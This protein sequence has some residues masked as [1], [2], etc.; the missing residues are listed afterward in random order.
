MELPVCNTLWIGDRLGPITAACLAS[1]VRHGHRVRLYAYRPPADV[2]AGV[3]LADAATVLPEQ[4]IVRHRRSGSPALFSNRFRYTLLARDAGLWIDG[5]L[6][7]VRPIDF[8]DAAV[9]GFEIPGSINTAVL[10]LAPDDPI[11]A[12]L[13]AIFTARTAVPPWVEIP[14]HRR[15]LLRA[16][17][18]LG[19]RSDL[20]DLPW[21]VTG[22]RAVTWLLREAGR[23]DEAHPVDVFYPLHWDEIG[24]LFVADGDVEALVTPR[25]RTIHLWN[26]LLTRRA[27]TDAE[28]G[29]FLDRLVA[30]TPPF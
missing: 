10:R 14:L 6:Y 29:S 12:R 23:F 22:P 20:G 11:L 25:T 2:P 13:E 21:G 19:L 28:K 5:D 9:F 26:N 1:F 17:Q 24:R 3:E 30:G 4:A 7:C 15:T 8:P 16:K 27:L 18:I